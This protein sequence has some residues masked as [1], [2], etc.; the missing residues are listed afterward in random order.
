MLD[1]IMGGNAVRKIAV[2]DDRP[3]ARDAMSEMVF[4]AGFEPVPQDI[5]EGSID[6]FL[7]RMQS[8]VHGAVFD[9]HLSPNNYAGF[10]GSDAVVKL[11]DRKF[12]AILCTQIQG[13]G[14]DSAKITSRRRKIPSFLNSMDGDADQICEGI[15]RSIRELNDEIFPDRRE[16]RTV[17]HVSD[18][19]DDTNRRIVYFIVP[20]WDPLKSI[21]VPYSYV[22]EMLES[23]LEIGMQLVANVN[24]G[25]ENYQDLFFQNIS[26][27]QGIADDFAKFIHS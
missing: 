17:I 14:Y 24:I 10:D 6:A 11:Y 3:D 13:G 20:A 25:A 8:E 15:E 12:P 23:E 4:D 1:L 18:L 7:D 16:Y 5:V 27:T 21:P 26:N 9:Y 19:G 2:V 22:V